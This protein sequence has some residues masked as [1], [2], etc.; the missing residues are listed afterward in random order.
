M[1]NK[2]N[3]NIVTCKKKLN[4]LRNVCEE[5]SADAAITYKKKNVFYHFFSIHGRA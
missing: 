4:F 2:E 1:F 5:Y 3:I